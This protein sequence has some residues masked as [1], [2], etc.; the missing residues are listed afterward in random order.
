M[1]VCEIGTGDTW[2]QSLCN[3]VHSSSSLS[4]LFS[5]TSSF[6]LMMRIDLCSIRV[7]HS[8]FC[9][10]QPSPAML[11]KVESAQEE[12]CWFPNMTKCIALWGA[13]I[14]HYWRW[15]LLRAFSK[16]ACWDRI[17]FTVSMLGWQFLPA[18]WM[19]SKDLYW[20][21]WGGAACG[22]I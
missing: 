3:D 15:A 13:D 16:N 8:I 6:T 17:D 2:L 22:Y 7:V 14:C 1:L 9:I 4:S 12:C 19:S 5:Y 18:C 21:Q 10:I 20:W 11:Q